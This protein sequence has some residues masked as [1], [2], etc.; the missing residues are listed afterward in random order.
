MKKALSNKPRILIVDDNAEMLDGLKLFLSPHASEIITHRNP[1]LIPST[2]QQYSFDLILLDMNFAA[3]VNTGNEGIYW[4]RRILEYDPSATIVLITGYGDIDLA[5]K[6]MKEGAADFIQKS[7]DEE[8]ILSSLQTA[9]KIRESRLEI[10]SLKNKTEHLEGKIADEQVICP[11][12]SAIM[13]KVF[14]TI[15]KVA[16]TEANVLILGENGT[17]KEIIARELHRLSARSAEMF[18][19]VDMASLPETLFESELFGYKKGAF[20]DAFENKTGYFEIADGGTLFLDEIGNLSLPMQAKILSVL[21]S[22]EFTPLGSIKKI[23]VD[24]RL[25][26]AT[27]KNLNSLLEEGFFRQDLLYRINTIQVELPPLRERKEDIP[28]LAG[29]FLKQ[30]SAKYSRNIR[31]LSPSALDKLIS[32]SWPGNVRELQH[33]IEKAVILCSE[34]ELR[35]PDFL[36]NSRKSDLHESNCLNLEENEKVLVTMAIEKH[37]GNISQAAKSLG[38]NRST[39]Y[40]KIRRY[41]L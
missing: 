27:N 38:I 41:G 5:I 17:G 30:Y 4:M 25:I 26:S 40:E 7:W 3:G 6:A 1:N 35:S 32:H 28:D 37:R 12:R 24:I 10:K 22:R 33:A 31:E 8:R 36:F 14:Q 23:P 9:L 16:G 34:D 29:F 20:T 39:L 18:V 21:Q 13:R 15:E 19:T 11:S 2:L